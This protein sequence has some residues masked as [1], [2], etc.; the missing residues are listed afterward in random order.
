MAEAKTAMDCYNEIDVC[1]R[2]IS[3]IADLVG[4]AGGEAADET[5]QF[6]GALISEKAER[7]GA[8]AES[9]FQLAREKGQTASGRSS[10][11]SDAA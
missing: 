1:V 2:E 3:A 9:L 7:V 5:Y 10:A 6:I 11:A 8:C 4:I